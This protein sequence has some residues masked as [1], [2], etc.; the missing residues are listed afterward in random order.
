MATAVERPRARTEGLV[1]KALPDEVLVHDLARHRTHCLNGPAAAVW[2]LC[3]GQ[4]TLGQ[5]ARQL[6]QAPE[7]R[8]SDEAV[9][10]ALDELGRAHLLTDVLTGH[11]DAGGVTRR[12]TLQR[13]AAAAVVVPTVAT[14]VAP[15][16]ADAQSVAAGP[17]CA[18]VGQECQSLTNLGAPPCC[19]GTGL[20]CGGPIGSPNTCI[21]F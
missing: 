5:I 3:D 11:R 12:Q 8:W 2:R 9:R 16:A 6:G 7:A 15:R 10:L 19:T 17:L 4:R 21:Q 13:L 20:V 18:T 14:I 1:I